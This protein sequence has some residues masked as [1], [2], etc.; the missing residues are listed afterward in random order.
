MKIKKGDKVMVVAGK[1]R[2]TVGEVTNV[3]AAENK[4]IVSGVNM[5]KRHKRAQGG[6]KGQIVEKPMP[7]DASNVM[8]VDPKTNTPTRI[9]IV[10]KEGKRVRVTKKSGSEI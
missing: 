8:F 9:G 1:D 3:F 10:R 4:V 2:G 6:V 5:V 7:I